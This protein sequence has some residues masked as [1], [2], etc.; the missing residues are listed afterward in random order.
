MLFFD[1]QLQ[2]AQ[3][4]IKQ[5][6]DTK[7]TCTKHKPTDTILFINI[8]HYCRSELVYSTWWE[9]SLHIVCIF[10]TAWNFSVKFWNSDQGFTRSILTP[11][12]LKCEASAHPQ[13]TILFVT[14][15]CLRISR[16]RRSRDFFLKTCFDLSIT[17]CLFDKFITSDTLTFWLAWRVTFQVW[18]CTPESTSRKSHVTTSIDPSMI[19]SM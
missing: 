1:A 10:R 19:S 4:W 12:W 11:F 16:E 7:T 14:I 2:S 18:S 9:F 17:Y 13:I 5:H 3:F 8:P 6:L 15:Y